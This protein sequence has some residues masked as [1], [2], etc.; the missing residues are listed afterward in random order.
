MEDDLNTAGALGH[1]FTLVRL[2][3]RIVEDKNWKKSEQA[4]DIFQRIL[5]DLSTWG[6][7]LGIFTRDSKTLLTELRTMRA[8]RRGIDETAVIELM[9]Q[10]AQARKDKD[11]ARADELRAEL[12]AMD[13]TIQDTPQGA[14]WDVI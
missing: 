2:A 12:T 10:R 3:N 1:V 6:D 5:D 9:N 11:F 14:T 13:V 8:K 4:R 7:I